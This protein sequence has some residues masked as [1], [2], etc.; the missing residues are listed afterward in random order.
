ML[1]SLSSAQRT[2]PPGTHA[3]VWTASPSASLD[4]SHRSRGALDRLS[5]QDTLPC[6]GFSL[7]ALPTR[8]ARTDQTM[9][10]PAIETDLELL[11]PRRSGAAPGTNP[12]AIA[13]P[14]FVMFIIAEVSWLRGCDSPDHLPYVRPP[15]RH[16]HLTDS[17]SFPR[18]KRRNFRVSFGR[19]FVAVKGFLSE[20]PHLLGIDSSATHWQALPGLS[21]LS[22]SRPR[23]LP[24]VP[25]V[26]NSGSTCCH[27][28]DSPRQH[29]LNGRFAPESP[30]DGLAIRRSRTALS[31]T[32]SVGISRP[33]FS[34]IAH[35]STLRPL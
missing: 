14:A 4:P 10:G 6:Y 19:R 26:I 18:T 9:I 5:I 3:R 20:S 1:S 25:G 22:Y 16:S 29:G 13:L 7:E 23:D 11:S 24:A 15:G 21:W 8:D 17:A 12:A 33:K 31:M 35:D 2:A 28:A 30:R 32:A 34:R 27:V